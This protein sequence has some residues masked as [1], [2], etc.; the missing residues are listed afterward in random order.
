MQMQPQDRSSRR[1]FEAETET[2]AWSKASRPLEVT[3][4]TRS[5]KKKAELRKWAPLDRQAE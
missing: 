1:T 2:Y 5:R 3:A 4:L